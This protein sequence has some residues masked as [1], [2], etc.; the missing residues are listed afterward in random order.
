MKKK[1]SSGTIPARPDLSDFEKGDPQFIVPPSEVPPPTETKT[2][3]V[4]PPSM[5]P[6][7]PPEPAVTELAPKP[8]VRHPP[9][10]PASWKETPNIQPRR[11]LADEIASELMAGGM[12]GLDET[13]SLTT[14]EPP[15]PLAQAVKIEEHAESVTVEPEEDGDGCAQ[16]N[17]ATEAEDGTAREVESSEV[18]DK[19]APEEMDESRKDSKSRI[20]TRKRLPLRNRR[21]KTATAGLTNGNGAGLTNGRRPGLTNGKGMTNGRGMTNGNGLRNRKGLSNGN[22]LTNGNGF[23]NGRRRGTTNGIVNGKGSVN[24]L[25]RRRG[26][27]NGT[28]ID[29]EGITN[30]RGLTNG[31]GIVNGQGL[32]NGRKAALGDSVPRRKSPT[33]KIIA[34]F[35]IAVILLL[36]V[37]YTALIG[38][39]KGIK[40]DGLFSDWSG[41]KRYSDDMADQSNPEINLVSV[42]MAV[43]GT[44]VSFYARTE[45]N[46]L[47]GRNGGVDSCYVFI[48]ADQRT[49]TG[50]T[51]DSVGA[52]YVL[53]ID[54]YEGRVSAAGLYKFSREQGRPANDWNS[55]SAMGSMRAAV[56]GNEMEA[57]TNLQD[58]G[59]GTGAKLNVL[60]YEKDSSGGDDFSVVVSTEKV[61]GRLLCTQIG[62]DTAVAGAASIPMTRLDISATGGTLSVSTIN[63]HLNT[64]VPDGD[65]S[66]ISLYASGYELPGA[67]AAPV[68]GVATITCSP[69]M[70]I[71]KGG[72][73]SVEV[74]A[75][76]T[77]SAGAGKAFGLSI[78]SPDD[79]IAST[80]ALTVE[81]GTHKLTYIGAAARQINI[82]GAFSDWG[83]YLSHPDTAGDVQN[84]NIDVT[85]FKMT[86]DTGNFY[87]YLKVGGAMMGGVG[88]PETKVKATGGGGGGGGGGSPV[89]LPVLA[90]DDAFF[91]FIDTDNKSG[92]GYIGGGVPLGADCMINI[93]GQYGHISYR[94]F[95]T[96]TGGSDRSAWSWSVGIDVA[97]ASASTELESCISMASLGNPTGNMSLFYYSTD[98]KARKDTGNKL[99]YDLRAGGG[100]ALLWDDPLMA[101]VRDLAG[102]LDPEPLHAPEF[103]DILLPMIG[104]TATF[105]IIRRRGSR[106]RRKA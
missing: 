62:P 50:Y 87:F 51:I 104:M 9:A 16:K 1:V 10:D 22:G 4:V 39:E 60:F 7:P 21:K 13:P 47:Q 14:S 68:G 84:A 100:R 101:G 54:G 49:S 25:G 66:R 8:M 78:E 81:A 29:A 5:P 82:D 28:L 24:G 85:D 63:V 48:D 27:I 70:D 12:T 30:G 19:E 31:R 36:I 41:V 90:G 92:T 3:P 74:R 98:W 56:K 2:L 83:S 58:L 18:R 96:F 73:T 55:R 106:R 95:H 65:I 71:T 64:G 37:A 93:S 76:L 89:A 42:A 61:S 59:L 17:E 97:A 77:A 102:T 99:T 32:T 69:P 26:A 11:G 86:N 46:A 75:W 67:S 105:F 91:V 38:T 23:V 45:G 20:E 79:I 53:A 15:A 6:V 33:G 57:Q 103:Q 88:I 34:A 94:K 44:T 80:K 43:E 52:E 35:M 72:T 40:V